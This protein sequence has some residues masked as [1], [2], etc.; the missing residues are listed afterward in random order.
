MIRALVRYLGPVCLVCS[1][2]L[3]GQSFKNPLI[4][5]TGTD[6]LA[7]TMADVNGDGHPDILYV[8]ANYSGGALH[9]LTGSGAGTF[10]RKQ[11]VPLPPGVCYPVCYINLGDIN[12]DGI[13]DIVLNATVTGT[14]ASGGAVAALLGNGDGTFQSPIVSTFTTS[15]YSALTATGRIGIGDVNEDGA[16]DLVLP[17][18]DNG[19]IDV[20]LGDKTGHF[21]PGSSITDQSYPM[22]A[23]LRDVNGDGHLDLITLSALSGTAY[24]AFG[25]GDG[26][27][28]TGTNYSTGQISPIFHD[29]DGD[30]IPDLV[31]GT[32]DSTNAVYDLVF[33]KGN[34]D[35]TFATATALTTILPEQL[36]DIGDYAGNGRADLL[37]TTPSGF[38][39]YPR[40]SDGTY[41]PVVQTAASAIGRSSI[42]AMGDI[43]GDG[44][45]DIA[46]AIAGGIAVFLGNGDGS[47][48]SADVYDVGHPV[49]SAALVSF[50][51]P[52]HVDIAVQQPATFPRLLLGDGT[53]SFKLSPDPNS[54][55]GSTAATGSLIAGD[56]NGDGNTDLVETGFQTTSPSVLFGQSSESFTTPAT[57]GSTAELVAD[58]NNDGRADLILADSSGLTVQLG[59]ANNTFLVQTMPPR[60][61]TFAAAV[62]VGDLNGDGKP[63]LIVSTESGL[64][65]YLGNG[66]G[67][68]TFSNQ[69]LQTELNIN[70]YPGSA[71][72]AIADID[73][74]GKPDL[75]YVGEFQQSVSSTI[76]HLVVLPG[77]GDGT[78]GTP[79]V[80]TLQHPYTNLQ[81]ADINRDGKPDL[82][83]SDGS[84]L[85]VLMNAGNGTF[86]AE[87]PLVA[88]T[89]VGTPVV[90]DVNGDGY[91]DI[92]VPNYGGTTVTVL[93]NETAATP[94]KLLTS[95]LTVSP[96]PSAYGQPITVAL[97]T[98]AQPQPTG[99]VSFF[100][101]GQFLG[102]TTFS[103]GTAAFTYTGTLANGSHVISAAYS[104]DAVYNPA[105]FTSLHS[106]TDPTYATST[107]LT[108]TPSSTLTTQTVRLVAVVTDTAGGPSPTGYVTFMEGSVSLGTAALDSTGTAFLDTS[109]L[110]VGAHNIIASFPGAEI[111]TYPTTSVLSPSSSPAVE[112]SISALATS[113]TMTSSSSTGTAGT[114]LSFTATV[115]SHNGT[116]FGGVTFLDGTQP[117]GTLALTGNQAVFSTASLANGS[118]IITAVFNANNT[119]ASSSSAALPVNI[120]AAK[121][122]LAPTLMTVQTQALANGTAELTA[123][124]SPAAAGGIVTFL[125]D[126]VILGSASVNE[127]G[128]AQISGFG[129]KGAIHSITASV[130]PTGAYAPSASP[131]SLDG[132]LANT[133]TFTLSLGAQS[134]VVRPAKSS[135]LQLSAV[136]L[137]QMTGSVAL[138]CVVPEGGDYTCDV[139]SQELAFGRSTTITVTMAS[140]LRS[141]R[142]GPPA[143]LASLA[144]VWLISSLR[145]RRKLGV[146]LIVTLCASTALIGC[147]SVTRD[148]TPASAV[149]RIQATGATTVRS[150]EVFINP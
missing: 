126:G 128:V 36:L 122:E 113:T 38:G 124:V 6:P 15:Y 97:T 52:S 12:G 91:P 11:D 21:H 43:N 46:V 4:I 68:F 105:S 29:V 47:F 40:N 148:V 120:Q 121:R 140:D 83:L 39:V 143:Y 131:T 18:P 10:Q 41:A 133:P 1:P 115:S 111:S 70:G 107:A 92:A 150:V 80:F 63:D 142:Y 58:V 125:A 72:A 116:P 3:P 118:H 31:F 98:T 87:E 27:F 45:P 65:I 145:K 84:A 14:N 117:L 146:L 35:G 53:G 25:K 108:A 102:A 81:V 114:V 28:A 55:Y 79:M 78:F 20:L 82:V 16:A 129:A 13:P 90:G 136:G 42:G 141:A 8:E 144:F 147:G 110:G 67:T 74:D 51:G 103:A 17:D 62:A 132:W 77:N 112:V 71:S 24:V 135:V 119:F 89:F 26:T 56:F 54:S 7:V 64:D 149:L 2:T 73:G 137:S 5:P 93:L 138:S 33:S 99:A 22:N 104:G 139:G 61:S 37:I 19:Q 30:G 75:V 106:V 66:D 50:A 32:Y 76:P 85:A 69:I 48:Q 86:G 109:T 23:I 57:V 127:E 130:A 100:S 49:N 123:T 134:V 60:V 96:E 9:V 44:H 101:D 34:A 59:Q 95:T 94:A 88:G